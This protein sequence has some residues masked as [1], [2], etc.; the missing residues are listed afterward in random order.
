M[1]R[2]HAAALRQSADLLMSQA[3]TF[4]R[5]ADDH[6][7]GVGDLPARP[8]ELKVVERDAA[9]E[10]EASEPQVESVGGEELSEGMQEWL[11]QFAP[12]IRN[13]PVFAGVVEEMAA[14]GMMAT[15]ET[16]QLVGAEVRRR[17]EMVRDGG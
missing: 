14:K 10:D 3:Q 11:A 13:S 7:R 2:L 5:L 12:R 15:P 17:E 1:L 16:A 6:D 9:E 8:L 4:D